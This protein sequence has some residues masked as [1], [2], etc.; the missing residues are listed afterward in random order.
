MIRQA[1][2]T[3]ASSGIGAATAAALNADA[4]ELTLGGR[5][6]DRL[7]GVAAATRAKARTL[8]VTD[9][10]S[11]HEFAAQIDR[12][13]LLVC[14]AGG[15]V[16]MERIEEANPA[17]WDKMWSTNVMGTMRIIQA[18]LPKLIASGDG[19]IVLVGS[20]A[21]LETYPGG[22]GYNATKYA[23]RALRDV[24]RLELVGRPVRVS[25]VDPGMVS[26]DFSLIRFRGDQKRADAVYAGMTPLQATD[27]AECI[28]WIASRPNHVN[29]DRLIVQ[30][31]DQADARTVARARAASNQALWPVFTSADSS[32]TSSTSVPFADLDQFE[33]AG[34]VGVTD[35]ALTR[36]ERPRPQFQRA[37]AHLEECPAA[38]RPP[39]ELDRVGW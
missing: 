21:G 13:E 36:L 20:L 1:V 7:S 37:S 8:D 2:I 19:Q 27:V 25:E 6:A 15:A 16:G 3:G 38:G 18:L 39:P 31:R 33:R 9:P 10:R 23:V 32:S 4:W 34:M 11:I 24:L 22:G 5:R 29:I 28:R 35:V 14:S 30:P 12:V 26:T 17:D